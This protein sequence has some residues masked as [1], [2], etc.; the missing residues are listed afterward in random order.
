MTTEG[1]HKLSPRCMHCSAE[2]TYQIVDYRDPNG[3]PR[4]AWVPKT[5]ARCEPGACSPRIQY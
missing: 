1:H 5:I 3:P 2:L 4:W